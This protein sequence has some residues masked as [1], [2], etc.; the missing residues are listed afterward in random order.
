MLS[1]LLRSIKDGGCVASVGNASGNT[2]EGSV[3]PFI[4]RRIQLFGVMANAPWPQ[5]RRLWERLGRDLKPD[6]TKLLPHIKHIRLEQLMA[7]TDLQLKG[8]TS[9]RVLVSYE[10]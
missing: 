5:R 6:F 10:D 8:Q 9:G 7:H 4:M 1:W 3:L 2:Y